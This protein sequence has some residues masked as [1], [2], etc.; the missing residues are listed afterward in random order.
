MTST[1]PNQPT[2]NRSLLVNIYQGARDGAKL[3]AFFG[4]S[5]FTLGQL[6]DINERMTE[7]SHRIRDGEPKVP[8][9]LQDCQFKGNR[10]CTPTWSLADNALYIIG[11]TTL[12]GMTVG[13]VVGAVEGLTN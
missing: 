7:M 10:Y 6:L 12:L 9:Y 2:T 11:L 3:G 8:I 4:T 13:A 1:N 5:V